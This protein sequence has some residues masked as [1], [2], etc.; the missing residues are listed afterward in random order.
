MNN[1]KFQK[2]FTLLEL[3]VAISLFVMFMAIATGGFVKVLRT[4]KA[5]TALMSANDNASLALEQMSREMR[6]GYNF[7]TKA[8]PIISIS[9]GDFPECLELGDNEIMFVN[10][11]NEVVSYRLEGRA[12]ERVIKN[13]S[14]APIPPDKITGDDVWVR[15]FNIELLGNGKGDDYPPRITIGIEVSPDSD[16]SYLNDV[17]TRIQTTISSRILDS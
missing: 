11:N 7:C 3:L 5:M 8:Q 14:S 6:T 4:Q 10:V 1:L 15:K 2:G 16:I 12:I 9:E 17:Y 13:I